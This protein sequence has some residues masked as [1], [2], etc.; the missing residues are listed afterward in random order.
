MCV[1][2]LEVVRHL[3][4]LALLETHPPGRREFEECLAG[5]WHDQVDVRRG[6]RHVQQLCDGVRG[7]KHDVE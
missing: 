3:Q 4:H 5:V 1:N 7:G 6:V 2:V